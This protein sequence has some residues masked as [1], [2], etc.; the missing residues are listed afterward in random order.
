[1]SLHRWRYHIAGLTEGL[2]QTSD[3][4][5]EGLSW[6]NESGP[7]GYISTYLSGDST[8]DLD[9]DPLESRLS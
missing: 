5:V 7:I 9:L 2:L 8:V 1:M 4:R 3:G 6:L